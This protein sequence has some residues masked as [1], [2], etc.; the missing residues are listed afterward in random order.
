[1]SEIQNEAADQTFR[2]TLIK[3]EKQVSEE[4]TTKQALKKCAL[5]WA[6]VCLCFHFITLV[7]NRCRCRFT[8][9]LGRRPDNMF[10]VVH[11][12]RIRLPTRPPQK[13]SLLFFFFS[14]V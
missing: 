9:P 11:T 14:F 5:L 7:D 1:M 3:N 13:K 2:I 8:I 6:I 10:A 4:K 12:Y